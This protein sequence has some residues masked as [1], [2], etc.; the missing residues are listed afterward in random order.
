MRR[1]GEDSLVVVP[2]TRVKHPTIRL[3]LLVFRELLLFCVI[4][5]YSV[6]PWAKKD[7]SSPP[8]NRYVRFW[9]TASSANNDDNNDGVEYV[10]R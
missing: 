2:V 5:E 1:G 7:W 6:L 10:C 4:G 3:L 9:D 8:S